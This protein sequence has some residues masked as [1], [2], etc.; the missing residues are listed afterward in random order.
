MPA[1]TS[2][3]YAMAEGYEGLIADSRIAMNVKSGAAQGVIP[4]GYPVGAESGDTLHVSKFAKDN[5]SLL[6]DADFVTGNLINGTVNGVAW[7]EVAFDTDQATTLAALI[8]A[9]DAIPGVTATA[10]A[11]RTVLI[12][13]DDSSQI[14]VTTVVT[15]GASQATGTPTY[16]SD[17]VF[18]GVAVHT[19]KED[20]TIPSGSSA[21]YEDKE[22][23]GYLTQGGIWVPA[24][25][26]VNADETAYVD[27]AAGTGKFTNV[28]TDNLTTGGKFKK[29][30][31]AAGLTILELPPVA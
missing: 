5:C 24:S 15:G 30:I 31:A 10:G 7:A 13:M 20:S 14:T 22:A 3:P 19:H 1:Q 12:E 8:A 18:R 2:Y 27:L 23:V 11:A 26:A 28:A 9:V 4:F 16:S 6:Y 29:T 17:N 21:Q 25:V